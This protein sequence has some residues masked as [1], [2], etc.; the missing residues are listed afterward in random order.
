MLQEFAEQRIDA[1]TNMISQAQ[2]SAEIRSELDSVTLAR[3]L[4]IA[5]AG[6]AAM[7]KGF[8]AREQI[9]ENLENLI[10]SWT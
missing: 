2:A 9:V 7:A 4:M 5:L 3:G 8:M 6:S 10:D 1:L